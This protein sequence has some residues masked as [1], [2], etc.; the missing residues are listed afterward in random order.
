MKKNKIRFLT[1]YQYKLQDLFSTLVLER[2]HYNPLK[3]SIIE[4]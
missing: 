4:I 1:K 3:P 2:E